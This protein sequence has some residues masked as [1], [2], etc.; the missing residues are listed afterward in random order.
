M[1]KI[2]LLL[3]PA[4]LL[5][6]GCKQTPKN[7][8]TYRP[9][10]NTGLQVSEISIGCG[11]FEKLDTAGSI[12]LMDMAIDSGMNYIDIYDLKPGIYYVRIIDEQGM[13]V[14]KKMIKE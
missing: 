11:G 3:L 2:Y 8:M 5:A 10:G 12:A 9:L 7:A 14:I 4:L 6:V 1:K 13:S